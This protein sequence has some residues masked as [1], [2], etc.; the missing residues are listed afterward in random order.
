MQIENAFTVPLPPDK[1]LDTLTDV[2]RIAPCLPGVTLTRTN[3][4]G[5]YEGTAKVRLGTVTLSF[6]GKARIEEI[7]RAAQQP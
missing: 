7:D 6:A 3:D 2:P 5:S 4:D 1:A